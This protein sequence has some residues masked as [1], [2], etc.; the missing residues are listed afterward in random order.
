MVATVRRR[1]RR[2]RLAS[3]T[4]A[5]GTIVALLTGCTV[6]HAGRGFP[7]E[8]DLY[9]RNLERFDRALERMDAQLTEPRD[10][11]S[12][13]YWFGQV[14]DVTKQLEIDVLWYQDAAAKEPEKPTYL[15]RSRTSKS[16]QNILDLYH[17]GG[18]TRDYALLG[19]EL[20]SLAPTP[21][22]S[23]PT[24][25]PPEENLNICSVTGLST[26]CDIETAMWETRRAYP[27]KLVKGIVDRPDGG[28]E[29]RTGVTLRS[30]H[31]AGVLEFGPR[32]LSQVPESLMDDLLPTTVIVDKRGKL[33]KL[34]I[35]G[36]LEGG[37]AKVALEIGYQV[38]RVATRADFPPFPSAF[39]VTPL[40]DEKAR[41]RFYD[42]V[43][44]AGER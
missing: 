7:D 9:E 43:D 38:D 33:R 17:R 21:W 34:S 5:L 25:H 10:E 26:V 40:P 44:E 14:G 41:E 20:R 4:V 39:D 35:D 19:K 12:T 24:F 32:V 11:K 18:S 15:T 2:H 27:Q 36:E 6:G 28:I 8:Q 31:E 37:G 42:K 1:G 23:F 3:V 16:E 13:V 30:V 22:V 29:L